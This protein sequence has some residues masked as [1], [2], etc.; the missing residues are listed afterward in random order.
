MW[1]DVWWSSVQRC[2]II[3][4]CGAMCDDHHLS[5]VSSVDSGYFTLDQTGQQDRMCQ[6]ESGDNDSLRSIMISVDCYSK[7]YILTLRILFTGPI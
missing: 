1:C 2:V 5:V 6:Q 7:H 3:R 4:L